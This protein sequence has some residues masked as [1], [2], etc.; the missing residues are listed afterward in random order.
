VIFKIF[1]Y[2][3]ASHSKLEQM[4]KVLK[5]LKLMD[6]EGFQMFDTVYE[7]IRKFPSN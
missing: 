1:A 5:Q 6:K 4:N 3:V 2:V 7:K